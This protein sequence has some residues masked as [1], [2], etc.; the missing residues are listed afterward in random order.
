MRREKK[1]GRLFMSALI[2]PLA[3]MLAGCGA[4]GAGP[5]SPQ[6]QTSE[7]TAFSP[8]GSRDAGQIEI[9]LGEEGI[10]AAPAGGGPA[11]ENPA[12]TGVETDDGQVKITR[13]G[14]YRIRGEL[15]QGQILV[16]VKD[17]E[18][19]TLTLAG[20]FLSNTDQAAVY[21]E[22]AGHTVL[23]LEEGTQNYISS[24]PEKVTKDLEKNDDFMDGEDKKDTRDAQGGAI[25]A[26]DDL[27]IMGTGM[28]RVTGGINNGI[29]T[30]DRL[31]VGEGSVEVRALNHG[32]KGKDS[33]TIE[34][35]SLRIFSGGDGIRSDDTSGEGYGQIDVSGG[36]LWIRSG[37]NALRARTAL[38]VSGGELEI[39]G[40]C[41]GME[42]NQILISGG[43]LDIT[44]AE[45][46][47]NANGDPAYLAG[48]GLSRDDSGRYVPDPEKE[49]SENE[50][51]WEKFPNLVIRGGEILVDARGDGLDSNGNILIEGGV[52]IIDGP[53][54]D[55]DGPLDYG[56]ENGGLCLISGGTLLAVGSSAMAQTFG[57][58]SS[59]YAF[60]H[61]FESPYPAGSEISVISPEGDV[62]LTHTARKKGASV[63]FGSPELLPGKTYRLRVGEREV[64]IEIDRISTISGGE[65]GKR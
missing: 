23:F 62:L 37:G 26:R 4:A 60:R 48:G 43:E 54:S 46:G 52:T 34:G 25:Y 21:V 65:M 10:T 50:K 17:D 32:L 58:E 61:I 55:K 22:N 18:R 63:V 33:V 59:Q 27:A 38:S 2:C 16:E 8:A 1:T 3:F 47:I 45:D 29:H 39:A 44:A 5:E 15:A 40:S 35:G 12:D 14:C 42:A 31:T 7:G 41:E 36:C 11:G 30:A 56:Y 6:G 57:E 13:G 19:V 51:E 64:A 53:K 28:L 24:G 9:L 20:V 49:S